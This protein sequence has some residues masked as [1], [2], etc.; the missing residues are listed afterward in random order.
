M[1]KEAAAVPL[2]GS[3]HPGGCHTAV[4]D[5]GTSPLFHGEFFRDG[6]KGSTDDFGRSA[7]AHT[8]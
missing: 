7:P 8:E 6:Y 1:I 2:P 4:A 5:P 3:A